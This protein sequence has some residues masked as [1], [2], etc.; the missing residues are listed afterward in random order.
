MNKIGVDVTDE[1]RNKATPGKGSLIR[2]AG[3][4]DSLHKEEIEMAQWLIKML[5]L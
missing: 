1:Y 4:V 5:L 2:E 3:Y